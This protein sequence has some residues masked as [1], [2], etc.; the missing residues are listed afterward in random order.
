MSNAGTISSYPRM[1]S[2]SNADLLLIDSWNGS[3][4]VT[5]TITAS[6]LAASPSLI[7]NLTGQLPASVLN[8]V[9]GFG[10][11]NLNATNLTGKIP[12]SALTN[13]DGQ[14]LT[15]LPILSLKR[16][17]GVTGSGVETAKYQAA[18]NSQATVLFDITGT[19]GNVTIGNNVNLIGDGHSRI[20]YD[21]AATGRCFSAGT[22]THDFHLSNL[23][24]DGEEVGFLSFGGHLPWIYNPDGTVTQDASVVRTAIYVYS[25]STNS[26][27]FNCK[28]M[29]FSQFGY[30]IDGFGNDFPQPTTA[31]LKMLLNEADTCWVGYFLYGSG[32]YVV[33]N[34][35]Y[36]E[37]N[38]RGIHL[39]AGNIFVNGGMYTRN[40]EAVRIYGDAVNPA[41]GQINDA[42]FN[43]NEIGLVAFDFNNGEVFNHCSWL[44]A[45]VFG[46]TNSFYMTNVTGITFDGCFMSGVSAIVIDGGTGVT[47]G[48]NY[49]NHCKTQFPIPSIT[50][51]NNGILINDG[52]RI[53]AV[54]GFKTLTNEEPQLM[55]GTNTFTSVA[56]FASGLNSGRTNALSMTAT[57]FTN[58]N[59]Y[60]VRLIN[61]TNLTG[62]FSNRLSGVN[63]LLPTNVPYLTLQSNECVVGTSC[64]VSN[65]LA[66]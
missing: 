31:T 51:N 53:V 33:I 44:G 46:G 50:T 60:I 61:F 13:V 37:N 48:P 9:S 8:G 63:S 43:H 19:T 40:G 30:E 4:F 65:L 3:S 14:G 58:S 17:F 28:A 21:H 22:N 6:N 64:A 20:I 56:N 62:Y 55:N 45:G 35:C 24:F 27:I 42:I 2:V 11:V 29:R 10:L 15:N 1:G 25:G 52:Y 16:D 7:N 38:G 47:A 59:P 18:L 49:M 32:E 39:Q 57:G 5:K 66:L 36:G 12:L 34:D 26:S 41:H 23:I 54:G